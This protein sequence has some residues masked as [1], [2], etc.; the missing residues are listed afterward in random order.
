MLSETRSTTLLKMDNK[1]LSKKQ[2]Y[3]AMFTFLE[4]YYERGKS[5]EIGVML[6]SMSLLAD[7]GSADPAFLSDWDDAV[8]RVLSGD[9]DANLRLS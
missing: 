6:S 4:A 2:A 3:L 8:E 7:G 9:I 5:D 1:I